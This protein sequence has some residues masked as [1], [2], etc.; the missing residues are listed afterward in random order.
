VAALR[1]ELQRKYGP[2]SA[3][4]GL[5]MRQT[6]EERKT[7]QDII[8]ALPNMSYQQMKALAAQG[9]SVLPALLAKTP[10]DVREEQALRNMPATAQMP[11]AIPQ[12]PP[13]TDGTT[14]SIG[15][16]TAGYGGI[17][18]RPTDIQDLIRQSEEAGARARAAVPNIGLP[19]LT[20]EKYKALQKGVMPQGEAAYQDELF[21]Q[22]Q[23]LQGAQ[24]LA[25]G[26]RFRASEDIS[27]RMDKLRTAQEAR[28]KAKEKDI[29]T[30]RD[31]TVG[32][33]F[34]EA[35]QAMTQPGQSFLQGLA[36][37]GAAGGK[38][39]ME[40]KERL[41]KRADELSDA[42]LRLDEAR[43]GD[44]RERAK[45]KGELDQALLN[46]RSE[47]IK[48][49]QT[50]LNKNEATATRTVDAMLKR[51]TDVANQQILNEKLRL[52]AEQGAARNVIAAAG[53]NAQLEGIY[54]P[55]AQVELLKALG[56]GDL[57]K[58]LR[59]YTDVQAG[60]IAPEK[61]WTDVLT[62]WKRI[63]KEPPSY[64]EFLAMLGKTIG[65]D[66]T[67]RVRPRND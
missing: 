50:V 5:F 18:Q 43:V 51:E 53:V 62:H 41:D 40:D 14:A 58:G 49:Q 13:S 56:K 44:V 60:K 35:A 19:A 28:Y 7:A 23:E 46:S 10:V 42:I 61:L 65:G 37:S 4:V 52:D 20:P 8:A 32:I 12:T 21:P 64:Q 1:N 45:A 59:L 66:Q 30:D 47:M 39:Y 26:E 24:A 29:A 15:D 16:P 34:L 2:A 38:R 3:G 25:A 33:A 6:P 48:Y 17:G 57:E 9:P 11:A 22:V 27:D 54:K 67:G 55:T 36:R 31:R 63:D